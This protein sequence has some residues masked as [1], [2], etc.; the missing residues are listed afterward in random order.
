MFSVV[1][2]TR[3]E[4]NSVAGLLTCRSPRYMRDM[5]DSVT[6]WQAARATSAACS[7]FEPI[8]IGK[9]GE[10]YIDGATSCNNP[11]RELI[12]T[13]QD[14]WPNIDVTSNLACLVS[15]GTGQPS[16]Q[17]FGEHLVDVGK[18]LKSIATDTEYLAEQ[19]S[20]E[21]RSLIS[22]KKYFRFNVEKGLEDVGLEEHEKKS[23]IVAATRRHLELQH[24]FEQTQACATSIRTGARTVPA[25]MS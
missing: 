20:R 4:N 7:F 25:G 23:T 21:H 17:P 22:Q 18:T 9:F 5:L 3:A 8:T 13:A 6:I 24:V 14:I 19:F 10:Q 12:T 1:Y 2:A 16:L 15:I 11:V